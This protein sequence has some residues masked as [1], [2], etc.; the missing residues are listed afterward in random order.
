VFQKHKLA[1]GA[2]DHAAHAR[3][4]RTRQG[5]RADHASTSAPAT[6]SRSCSRSGR[7]GRPSPSAL[8][9]YRALRRVNPSPYL[10]LLEL[11]ELALSAPRRRRSSSARTAARA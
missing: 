1:A 2:L 5:V 11:G 7:S 4:A 10:F 6:R 9:L 8:E 3:P